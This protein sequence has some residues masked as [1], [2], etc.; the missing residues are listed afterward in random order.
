MSEKRG[1]GVGVVTDLWIST[2]KFIVNIAR[3]VFEGMGGQCS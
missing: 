1:K 2:G 3:Q